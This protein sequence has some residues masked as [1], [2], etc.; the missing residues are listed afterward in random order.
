MQVLL[1]HAVQRCSMAHYT[2]F[3]F[4]SPQAAPVTT[5]PAGTTILKLPGTLPSKRAREGGN[6]FLKPQDGQ[7]VSFLLSEFERHTITLSEEL[8]AEGVEIPVPDYSHS[9]VVGLE[10]CIMRGRLPVTDALNVM[11]SAGFLGM[12][13]LV[14]TVLS[15]WRTADFKGLNLS[16]VSP[17]TVEELRGKPCSSWP[18]VP[19]C[20]CFI[21]QLW[22]GSA[23][24]E[25][26]GKSLA[27]LQGDFSGLQPWFVWQVALAK[28]EAGQ[29]ECGMQ[30]SLCCPDALCK[31]LIGQESACAPLRR[32]CASC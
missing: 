16:Q 31:P 19:A 32:C 24:P 9:A 15:A 18:L 20:P 4:S 25:L 28:S 5:P 8:M 1:L 7:A 6:I 10:G 21:S 23:E 11:R 30:V 14:N 2:V 29:Y 12:S 3:S 27:D 13:T 17:K 26:L 22:A